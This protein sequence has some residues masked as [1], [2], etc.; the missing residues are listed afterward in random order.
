PF[1]DVR[2]LD[3]VTSAVAREPSEG[4]FRGGDAVVIPIEARDS[5]IVEDLAVVVAPT[6]VGDA[7][8]FQTPDVLGHE[9]REE[10]AGVG[11][12]HVVLAE[13]RSIED[14]RRV[15]DGEVLALRRHVEGAHGVVAAPALPLHAL[16]QR[17]RA[18]M[19][20][21]FDGHARGGG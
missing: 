15:A 12:T 11:T 3:V 7:A 6:H 20:W 13:R 2:D 10:R 18:R 8:L 5:S 9:P 17:G 14:P 4:G 21:G 19:K 16:A 1:G